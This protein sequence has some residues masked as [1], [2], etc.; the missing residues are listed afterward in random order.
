MS[1]FEKIWNFV[2]L[3]MLIFAI[4]LNYQTQKNLDAIK[5]LYQPEIYTLPV[6]GGHAGEVLLYDGDVLLDDGSGILSWG[7]DTSRVA[8]DCI[9]HPFYGSYPKEIPFQQGMT[10]MPGQSATFGIEISSETSANWDALTAIEE[11]TNKI[12]VY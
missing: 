10:I 4:F 8:E 9:N 12:S 7:V 1:K 11:D 3:V 2:L 6:R 5:R